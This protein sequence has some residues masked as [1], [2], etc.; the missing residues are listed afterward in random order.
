MLERYCKALDV[1][2]FN[3]RAYGPQSVLVRS[4]VPV[5]PDRYVMSL[6]RAQRWLEVVPG[7]ADTLPG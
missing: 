7:M 6:E 4:E 1:D 5:P 2:V 3:P